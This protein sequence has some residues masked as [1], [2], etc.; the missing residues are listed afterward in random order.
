MCKKPGKFW[1]SQRNKQFCCRLVL[2]SGI[3]SPLFFK[4][5]FLPNAHLVGA[6]LSALSIGFLCGGPILALSKEFSVAE[7]SLVTRLILQVTISMDLRHRPQDPGPSPSSVS[8][9]LFSSSP[10]E[11]REA[12]DPD[13]MPLCHQLL[14]GCV[15]VPMI[16]SA[17][18]VP[19]PDPHPR[20]S[21]LPGEGC[22]LG[23]WQGAMQQPTSRIRELG[24]ARAG[25]RGGKEQVVQ[26]PCLMC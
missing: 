21:S 16:P 15:L 23:S 11:K 1:L 5:K 3:P 7:G 17:A 25:V 14:L 8:S 4:H 26:G 6:P 9:R 20:P 24:L 19:L 2:P 18:S 10:M 13:R 12:A 22:G